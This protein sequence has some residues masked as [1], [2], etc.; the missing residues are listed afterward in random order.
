MVVKRLTAENM[1]QKIRK[2]ALQNGFKAIG[3]TTPN[4]LKDLPY[5]R[6]ADVTELK[7]P[8]EVLPQVKS[9]I[10]LALHTWDRAFFLQ[11]NSPE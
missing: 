1:T 2:L 4:K 3:I 6:V 5:G 8:E 7:R 10:V 9:V 11:I